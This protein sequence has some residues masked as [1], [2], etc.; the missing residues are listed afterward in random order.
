MDGRLPDLN[1]REVGE[2]QSWEELG[3]S[4]YVVSTL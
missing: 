2:E 4:N 3:L 1:L